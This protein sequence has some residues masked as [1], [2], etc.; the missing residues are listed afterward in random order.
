VKQKCL[1]DCTCYQKGYDSSVKTKRHTI[2]SRK[3]TTIF[4]SLF[5]EYGGTSC[6]YIQ[7]KGMKF[8]LTVVAKLYKILTALI[9]NC[10]R[11]SNMTVSYYMDSCEAR[12]K[13]NFWN[14]GLED[15]QRHSGLIIHHRIFHVGSKPGQ[16]SYYHSQ[17]LPSDSLVQGSESSDPHRCLQ[18]SF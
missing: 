11:P 5:Q 8:C 16:Q 13:E 15:Q 1:N 9:Q 7:N 14:L 4:I 12:A 18:G 6:G 2:W 3:A 10:M 17:V